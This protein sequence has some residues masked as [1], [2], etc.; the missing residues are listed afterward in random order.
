MELSESLSMPAS[1]DS[2]EQGKKNL[3]KFG[4]TVHKNFISSEKVRMLKERLEE[5][6]ELEI[7]HGLAIYA[8]DE[9]GTLITDD[10]FTPHVGRPV[11]TPAIQRISFLVNK[12]QIFIDLA[13]HPVA[14]S[15]AE[16]AFRGNPFSVGVQ[17]A[18]LLRKGVPP[19]EIHNDQ[20]Q[21]PFDTPLPMSLNVFV[22]LGDYDEDMGATRFVPGS[23]RGPAPT[24]TIDID[25]IETVAATM[26]AGSALLWESR[27][28]HAQGRPLSDRTRFS[29]G[30][31]YMLDFLKAP[32]CHA[33][34]IHDTV[35]ERMTQEERLLYGFNYNGVGRIGPRYPGDT[36]Q[37]VDCRMPYVT[38]LHRP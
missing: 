25:S 9:S 4:I 8:Y 21:M 6:A 38:E 14:L 12:G 15:Y 28:W 20:L 37:N 30:T 36:R 26:Q 19:Q 1:T 29:V 11:G 24:G 27:V 32:D 3:D 22:A 35:Y 23:H 33:T 5:Q 7:E 13:K 31:T 18:I 17:Q 10:Y 16:F 2:I 34:V